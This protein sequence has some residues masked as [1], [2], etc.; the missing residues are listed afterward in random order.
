MR[1]HLI[2]LLLLLATISAGAQKLEKPD[3][4]R[5]STGRCASKCGYSLGFNNRFFVKHLEYNLN[6]NKFYFRRKAS[7]KF[8]VLDLEGVEVFENDKTIEALDSIFE[9]FVDFEMSP[10][11]Y[12][13]YRIELIYCK[14][15]TSLPSKIKTMEFILTDNPERKHPGIIEKLINEYLLILREK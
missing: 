2:T 9:K 5:I 7:H 6:E 11:K 3:K 13:L 14:S 10:G 4:I 8:K 1:I 15:K 12:Y